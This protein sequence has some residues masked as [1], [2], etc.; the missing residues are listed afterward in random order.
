[1]ICKNC[2]TYFEG[3]RNQLYCSTRCKSSVNNQRVAV[4]DK[5]II[6]T[7]RTIRKNRNIAMQLH[8]LFGEESFSENVLKNSGL[9]TNFFTGLGEN[10]TFHFYDYA[11]K[12]MTD[13][14]YK[15]VKS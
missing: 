5:Q 10:N 12:P 11:I 13:R 7:E 8:K 6:A 3:R 14:T 2:K 1:M 15:I 9:D 4:R